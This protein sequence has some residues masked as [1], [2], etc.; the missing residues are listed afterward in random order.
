[1]NSRTYAPQSG[2]GKIQQFYSDYVKPV[3]NKVTET[4]K[5]ESL[6][7]IQDVAS[8]IRAGTTPLKA[9]KRA[10]KKGKRR[11]KKT[12]IGAGKRTKRRRG[13]KRKSKIRK[14]R[15]TKRRPKKKNKARK[16]RNNPF[17]LFPR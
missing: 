12:L 15:T 10:Y 3:V 16:P 13:T 5:K 2:G 4:V 1:M 8:D 9:M 6:D 7:T 11:L 14:K 17:D